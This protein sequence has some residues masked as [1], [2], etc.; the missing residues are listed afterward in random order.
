MIVK[1]WGT[2]E[3]FQRLL[4][5]LRQI[6]DR[7][8]G[9]SIAN[10]ATRWVLDHSF[11]GAVI[12]GTSIASSFIL[13]CAFLFFFT[14]LLLLAP[15]HFVSCRI[16]SVAFY[17]IL[18]RLSKMG[19]RGDIPYLAVVLN[20]TSNTHFPSPTSNP[21]YLPDSLRPF[22][23]LLSPPQQPSIAWPC[24]FSYTNQSL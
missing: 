14:L 8:S 19:R 20:T 15:L 13:I 21:P 4:S 3:L 12:I 9:R 16:L 2:W 22:S 6:G 24:L 18:H 1:A 10:V 17:S 5:M 23:S 7:H 11:V